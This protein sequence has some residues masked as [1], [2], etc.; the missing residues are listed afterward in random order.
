MRI[1]VVTPE[2]PSHEYPY[3]G[4]SIYQTLHHLCNYAEVQALCPLP[5]Y[6]NGFHPRRFDYRQSD[7]SCYLP[8][9]PTRY[10]NYPALP[11]VT[12]PVNGFT[13]AHYL[14]PVLREFRA[15]VILNFWLYPAGFAALR[16]GKKLNIPVVVGS[17]GSDLNRIPDALT[18]WLTRKTLTGATRVI[19]K[20]QQ[21]RDCAVSMGVNPRK[22]HIVANGCDDEIFFVRDRSCTRRELNI[23]ESAELIVY[24]GRMHPTKGIHELLLA[25]EKLGPKRPNLRVVFVGDGPEL[26][27]MQEETRARNLNKRVSFAGSCPPKEVAR[28]LAAANLLALPSHAEGYPNVVVEALACG[29]PV[30]ATNVGAIPEIVDR[31]RGFV[32]PVGA[33]DALSDALDA[34]LSSAWDENSIARQYRRSWQQVA[35]EVLAICEE[36]RRDAA[37]GGL[38]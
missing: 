25:V 11:L 38:H 9:V 29:R 16:V 34:T 35:E 5:R 15:D 7:L 31:S 21:L 26:T 1:A 27:H 23:P 37:N 33:I 32:V 28:W 8:D 36:S 2:F 17:I 24:V 22:A 13:C 12:R 14:E 18:R 6:P 4:R 30:V 3:R 20:S 19:A 10:L